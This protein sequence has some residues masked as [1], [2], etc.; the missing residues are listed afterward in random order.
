LDFLSLLLN[1]RGRWFA[2]L[3]SDYLKAWAKQI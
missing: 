2:L 1:E 3:I